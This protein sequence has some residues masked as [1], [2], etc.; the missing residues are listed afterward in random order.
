MSA[1][2]SDL[3]AWLFLLCTVILAAAGLFLQSLGSSVA[4]AAAGPSDRVGVFYYLAL[5]ILFE[6]IGAFVAVRRPRNPIGW[7]LAITAL[8]I[9]LDGFLITYATY[10]QLSQPGSLPGAE[11]VYWIA[12]AFWPLQW[13]GML[14]LLILFPDGRLLSSRWRPIAWLAVVIPALYALASAVYPGPASNLPT[15]SNPPGLAGTLA[16][17][18]Q[19]TFQSPIVTAFFPNVPVA[20][21]ASAVL[22]RFRKARGEQRQQLK[23]LA[24]ASSFVICAATLSATGLIVGVIAAIFQAAAICGLVLA[25]AIAVLRYR[26]Y[27]IDIIIHRTLVYGALTASLA[28][29]YFASVVLLQQ[30]LRV[31]TGQ[32]T[33]LAI[34]ASTLAIAALFQPLRRRIQTFFDQRFYR[35]KYDAAQILDRFGLTVRD[36]VELDQLNEQLVGVVDET[37]RPAHVSLWLAPVKAGMK[38]RPPDGLLSSPAGA[39]S[40]WSDKLEAEPW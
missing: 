18:F 40:R 26:L 20:V 8:T 7:L 38:S 21:S 19:Q 12:S 25:I 35:R 1:R 13:P 14:L 32:T 30:V 10:P 9:T 11:V 15:F 28:L 39:L 6:A 33:D 17:F 34:V 23:W 29:V 3:L 4:P 37:M 2:W 16:V 36:T 22:L 5:P 27:D 24:Y 31:L